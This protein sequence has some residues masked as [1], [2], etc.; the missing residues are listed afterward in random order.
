MDLTPYPIVSCLDRASQCCELHPPSRK[1]RDPFEL[2]R[3][4]FSGLTSYLWTAPNVV[5]G[6]RM[7]RRSWPAPFHADAILLAGRPR[8]KGFRQSEVR[9]SRSSP[10]TNDRR[11]RIGG[12]RCLHGRRQF[13]G[14]ASTLVVIRKRSLVRTARIGGT[15]A[16]GSRSCR[17]L[18]RAARELIPIG[19]GGTSAGAGKLTATVR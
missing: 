9:D 10:S 16:I 3:R 2:A 18:G 1:F 7:A 19:L 13:V 6:L 12:N 11:P 4:A 15:I 17:C 14:S 8:I 5:A